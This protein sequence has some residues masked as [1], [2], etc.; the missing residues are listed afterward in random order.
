MNPG[1]R[2]RR[3]GTQH[4][5]QRVIRR[6][7][8]GRRTCLGPVVVAAAGYRQGAL[9]RLEGDPREPSLPI[10]VVD[11]LASSSEPWVT[12][13]RTFRTHRCRYE[14]RGAVDVPSGRLPLRRRSGHRSQTAATGVERKSDSRPSR[15]R[16]GQGDRRVHLA[17]RDRQRRR[18]RRRSEFGL[19][20][21]PTPVPAQS[22]TPPPGE[23]GGRRWLRRDTCNR[24]AAILIG[25][26]HDALAAVPGHQRAEA[27]V[28]G[29]LAPIARCDCVSARTGRVRTDIGRSRRAVPL[30]HIQ[31]LCASDGAA[32]R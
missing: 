29:R 32:I 3:S 6:P 10:T 16:G 18:S 27:P 9:P 14:A 12:C 20:M 23:Y 30:G 22:A 2:S 25:G 7:I 11:P 4:H 31:P 15:R 5:P 13:L 1:D 19:P 21:Q 26:A 28:D 17:L 8:W 24:V